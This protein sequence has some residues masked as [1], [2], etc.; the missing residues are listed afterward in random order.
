MSRVYHRFYEVPLPPKFSLYYFHKWC[1]CFR[2]GGSNF[3]NGASVFAN[4]ASNFE[5]SASVF[6][7]PLI[8][9]MVPPSRF[10]K[11]CSNRKWCL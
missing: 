1:L 4:G 5:N 6:M 8:L 2:N 7:V 3:E 9:K 10:R 11:W